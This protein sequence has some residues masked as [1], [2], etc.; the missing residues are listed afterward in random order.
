MPRRGTTLR[1][2]YFIILGPP[3]HTTLLKIARTGVQTESV[4]LGLAVVALYNVPTVQTD[5]SENI[6][7]SPALQPT[8]PLLVRPHGRWHRAGVGALTPAERIGMAVAYGMGA[9]R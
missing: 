1:A 7:R 2:S 5:G 3:Q 4:P 6:N 8:S 9:T